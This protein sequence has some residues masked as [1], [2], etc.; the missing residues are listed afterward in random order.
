MEIKTN[1]L[2]V[3][4]YSEYIDNSTGY[5]RDNAFL[6]VNAWQLP[7]CIIVHAYRIPY[8]VNVKKNHHDLDDILDRHTQQMES[9]QQKPNNSSSSH[10]C[11]VIKKYAK[12]TRKNPKKTRYSELRNTFIG[13]CYIQPS[14][15]TPRL[16]MRPHII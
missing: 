1:K 10:R 8:Q 2:V 6:Q 13:P 9:E 12:K 3:D 11:L 4:L 16:H 15:I 7:V 14:N 5:C